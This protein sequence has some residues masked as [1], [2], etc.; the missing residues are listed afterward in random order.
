MHG[1]SPGKPL[2]GEQE[3]ASEL[4]RQ[5]AAA[6]LFSRR[7]GGGGAAAPEAAPSVAFANPF[8]A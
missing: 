3:M 2:S 7:G 6:P 4:N 8:G 1:S 5:R